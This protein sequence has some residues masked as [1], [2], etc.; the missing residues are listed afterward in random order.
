[1]PGQELEQAQLGV[2]VAPPTSRA[3]RGARGSGWSGSRRRRRCRRPGRRASPCDVVSM[4]AACVAGP[5]HRREVRAGGRAPRVSSRARRWRSWMLADPG[6]DRAGHPGPDPG[7][8]E[9]R[10]GEER[11]RGLAVGARDPDHCQLPARVAVPP[12]RGRRESGPACRRRRAAAAPARD[13]RLDQGGGGTG[14]GGRLDELVAV[15]VEPRDRHEQRAGSDRRAN[16]GSR[17]GSAIAASPAGPIARPSRRAPRARPS[18]RR[19]GRSARRARR[20]RSVRRRPGSRRWRRARSSAGPSGR[21][22]RPARPAWYPRAVV[23]P[24]VGTGQLQPLARRTSSCAGTARTAGRP[25]P[26]RRARPPRPRHRGPSR[27]Q[28]S[29]DRQLDRPPAQQVERARV[30]V[31][32]SAWS[33]EWTVESRPPW[34]YRTRPAERL[35]AGSSARASR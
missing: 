7:R 15:D 14:R 6:L 12:G 33:P 18:P 4:T 8:L 19:A 23:D 29:R 26:V 27:V 32:R 10:H 5:D 9:R 34:R 30:V 11:R 2:T 22:G 16:R 25:R 20:V 24:L 3:A 28:P 13:R 21:R 1:M 35:A 17:R 31:R